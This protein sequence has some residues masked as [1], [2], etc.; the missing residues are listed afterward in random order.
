MGQIK[1]QV[2][3]ALRHGD[4]LK[5]LV[6]MGCLLHLVDLSPLVVVA[7]LVVSVLEVVLG[8]PDVGHGQSW[9]RT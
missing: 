5:L 7:W 8:D 2:T 6:T 1:K 9:D 3:Y 4:F